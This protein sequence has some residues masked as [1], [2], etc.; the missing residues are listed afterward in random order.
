MRPTILLPAHPLLSIL[1]L[2]ILAT[3]L[4]GSVNAQQ[5]PPLSGCDCPT[6]RVDDEWCAAALVFEGTPYAVDTTF[7]Q[8]DMHPD[9]RD[10]LRF[11]QVRFTVDRVLKGDA[12]KDVIIRTATHR[13]NCAYRFIMG[14]RYMVFAHTDDG[15]LETDQCSHTRALDTISPEYRDSLRYVE[16]GHRWVEG[17]P[18]QQPCQ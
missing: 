10:A 18:V 3:G 14:Q 5:Y 13:D 11:V 2:A 7:A 1:L 8:A 4:H 6:A 12:P 16:R 17:K 9:G 15:A